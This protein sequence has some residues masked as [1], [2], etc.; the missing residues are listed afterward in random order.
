MQVGVIWSAHEKHLKIQRNS[1]IPGSEP[2]LLDLE[3]LF[4]LSDSME[5][6]Q[7]Y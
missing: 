4:L 5:N 2:V 7:L 1:K 3:K 6:L